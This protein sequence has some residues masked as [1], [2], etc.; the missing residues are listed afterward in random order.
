MN[1]PK[2]IFALLFGRRLPITSG[3][4]E[5]STEKR[6]P[7]QTTE[8]VEKS[9]TKVGVKMLSG[10]E[11]PSG[12]DLV[13]PEDQNPTI[14]IDGDGNSA[15]VVEGDLHADSH[16]EA[17]PGSLNEPKFRW[18]T[19]IPWHTQLRGV[20]GW[21]LNC[22]WAV[23]ALVIGSIAMMVLENRMIPDYCIGRKLL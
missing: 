17:A 8:H 3:K 5:V 6:T 10:R 7:S 20:S 1:F 4:L 21:T 18:N 2:L 22:Y 11:E 14:E 16:Q 23:W 15:I 19:K 13:R 9:E 12:R